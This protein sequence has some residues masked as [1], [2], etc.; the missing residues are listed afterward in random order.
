MVA[1]AST[2]AALKALAAVQHE[3][4]LRTYTSYTVA[5]EFRANG[6][7]DKH[8]NVINVFVCKICRD[9]GVTLA[10]RPRK[11]TARRHAASILI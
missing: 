7:K 1:A 10:F 11:K 2:P 3:V 8:D 9:A 5:F 4:E 6:C